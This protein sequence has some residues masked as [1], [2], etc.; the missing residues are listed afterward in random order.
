MRILAC[1][2]NGY[3]PVSDTY[4][5]S[6][7][8]SLG[9]PGR[10]WGC[11]SRVVKPKSKFPMMM[12][13][14]TSTNR[15]T[16]SAL[17]TSP[18]A[19]GLFQKAIIESGGGRSGLMPPR[20]LDHASPAGTPSA[21]SA[22]LAFARKAGV[23]GEGPEALAA[24]RSLPADAVVDGLNMASMFNP[25]YSG[26][27]IDGKVVVETPD[28]AYSAGRGA[29]IPLMIGANSMDISFSTART[30]DELFAPFGAGRDKAKA[31]YDP[32]NTGDVRGIGTAIAADQF[33]VEPAR[34]MAHDRGA[35]PAILRVQ[36]FV[37]R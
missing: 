33:M 26:P 6:W 25:T 29:R 21:E 34:F 20:Y 15:A 10:A 12:A 3:K 31:V 8:A 24:L 9:Q 13:D 36:L 22:G 1:I 11:G 27:M 37:R 5:R 30:M 14:R 32:G 7:L 16:S 23:P 19:T 28:A 17:M 2:S 18:L 35:G 4:I